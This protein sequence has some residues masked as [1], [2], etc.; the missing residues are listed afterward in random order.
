MKCCPAP[1]LSIP[2]FVGVW[3]PTYV[4]YAAG[5]RHSAGAPTYPT[6][7]LWA[8]TYFLP[9][10]LVAIGAWWIARR[11]PWASLSRFKFGALET[12]LI[13]AYSVVW[14]AGFFGLLYALAGPEAVRESMVQVIGF[15]FLYNLLIYGM[16]E[17]GFHAM[18]IFQEL[19]EQELAVV[20]ADRLRVRAEMEALRGQ[21]N[22]HFLFNSLHSIT[23]LVRDDP[24][25]AEEALLQFSALLRRL[26][27]LK[28]DSADEVPLAEEMRFVDD[29]LAIE[30]LRL[31]ERLVVERDIA[32]EAAECWL[33]A[34]S[35]QALV[36]NA[37][38]HA[39]APRRQGGRLQ[40]RAS[41]SANRLV[42]E[43][44]DDGPG[45]NP[46]VVAQATGVGLSVIRQRLQLRHGENAELQIVTAPGAGFCARLELPAEKE[47]V[48][49]T[50]TVASA[51]SASA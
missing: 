13:V 49:E 5:L 11:I 33:P 26:L 40:I 3:A 50:A 35:V 17:T 19:R 1:K 10:M 44:K 41:T 20:Q 30:Q 22:P 46:T 27:D 23:A 45:A 39:V 2:L 9:G 43:V 6:A 31:G 8:A 21:L 15:G 48:L 4:L 32:V 14:Q 16:Q 29:Y 28:R 51:A 18:R 25:R 42:V 24:K 47:S 37:I 12:G 34:F 7:F 38:H 36:E